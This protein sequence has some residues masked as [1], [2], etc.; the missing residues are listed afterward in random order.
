MLDSI[1][2]SMQRCTVGAA[3]SPTY[4]SAASS[5]TAAPPPPP[6]AGPRVNVSLHLESMSFT[7]EQAQLLAD[8]YCGADGGIAWDSEDARE[9]RGM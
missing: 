6:R 9:A 8:W 3:A 7:D 1:T 4:A 2:A 5:S